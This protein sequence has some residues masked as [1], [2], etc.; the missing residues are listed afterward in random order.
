[1]PNLKRPK[2]LKIILGT[3]A[4]TRRH[5]RRFALDEGY[6]LRLDLA[7]KTVPTTAVVLFGLLHDSQPPQ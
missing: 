4:S 2:L 1:M 6:P 5:P 3:I 7:E